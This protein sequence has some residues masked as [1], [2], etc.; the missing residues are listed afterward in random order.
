MAVFVTVKNLHPAEYSFCI[1]YYNKALVS[2]ADITV[3][4]GFAYVKCCVLQQH[5]LS[6]FQQ[7]DY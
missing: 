2:M 5:I 1:Y 6:Q 4:S 3:L 7:A